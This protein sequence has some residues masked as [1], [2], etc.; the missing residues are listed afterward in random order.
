[1]SACFDCEDNHFRC[2]GVRF[3]CYNCDRQSCS[4]C[5]PDA[6]VGQQSVICSNCTGVKK[7]KEENER[8]KSIVFRL[9]Y[10]IKG[11]VL[12][13]VMKGKLY[14]KNLLDVIVNY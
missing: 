1:M 8:L 4:Y 7:I 13:K 10:E 12:E 11:M 9:E 2:D 5:D 6:I 14:D 3:V